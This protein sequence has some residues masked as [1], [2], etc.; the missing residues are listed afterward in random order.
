[1]NL[2]TVTV[3]SAIRLPLRTRFRIWRYH[4]R[5]RNLTPLQQQ[6]IAEAARQEGHDFIFGRNHT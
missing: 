5:L 3:K 2:E 1:V 6:I 4:R